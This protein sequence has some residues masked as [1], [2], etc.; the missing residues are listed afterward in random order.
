MRVVS[1]LLVSV[2]L[3]VGCLKAAPEQAAAPPVVPD[4]TTEREARVET[5]HG[6]EVADPYR[7]LEDGSAEAVATWSERRDTEFRAFTD[8]LPLRQALYDRAQALWR[9]D[10]ETVRVECQVGQRALYR[11]K[12]ADQDK[13]VVHLAEGPD[14]PGRVV[15]DPNTW[16]R[17]ETLAGFYPSPDCTKA[18]YGKANAGDENPV[19][20]VLDLDTLEVGPDTFRG[21][22][23]GGVSWALDGSGVWYSSRPLAEEK[24]DG[25]HFYFPRVWWHALGAEAAQDRLVLADDEVKEYYHHV[26]VSEDG[27]WLL[28]YQGRFNVNRLWLQDLT[29]GD[30]GERIDVATELDGEYSGWVVGDRLVVLTDWEAPRRRVMTAPLATPQR[31]HWEELIPEAE[32]TLVSLS[33]VGGR[34]Y[35]E[36]QHDASSKILVYELDG[37][38]AGEVPLPTLGSAS[39]G[40]WFG[41][42]EVRV[43]FTSFGHPSSVY[44]YDPASQGALE[45]LKASGIPIEPEL[46][47]RIVVDQAW[48]HSKDGTEVPMFVVHA[49]A[50]GEAGPRPTLLTGYGGFD[51]SLTPKFSTTYAMWLEQGGVVAIPNLRGGGEFGK[52]W[53]EAGMLGRKQNVFDDF[54]GAAQW[55]IDEGWTTPERLAISGGSN[56]GLLVSAAVTQRPDLFGAV[57][58][59]V[60]LTDMVRYHKFGLANIWSEEY[61]SAEDPEQLKYL[62]AY[63]PYHAVQEGADYPAILVVGS[64]ND[65]RTD[66]A[67]ARKF[68]A[69]AQWADADRGG[70]DPILLDVQ[71]E[72]GHG[73]GVTIDTRADQFSRHHAFLMQAVGLGAPVVASGAPAAA[74]N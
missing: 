65:A 12:R 49:G 1:L 8:D 62:L 9:Y 41:K 47:E 28:L 36:Y 64:T 2:T 44:R 5:L 54:L 58:C 45:L 14:D 67:H 37:T 19:L 15:I 73:G 50:P 16:A 43:T 31:E 11:T 24:P 74:G 27:R 3:S 42:P 71:R 40:G 21:W 52:A 57:L 60:P 66:P 23:Q 55:L 25:G 51:I 46:L 72:S 22:R 20:A 34:L 18:V 56:G 30:H 4:P 10:D 70:Q 29:K 39:V 69:A 13:W 6:V 53:H 38:A 35:V 68:Y 17:T 32:D 63:S 7:W 59:S 48:F 33:P 26:D 61:G